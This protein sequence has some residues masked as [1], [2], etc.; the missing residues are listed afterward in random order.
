MVQGVS[1]GPAERRSESAQNDRCSPRTLGLV[2]CL[3]LATVLPAAASPPGGV[4]TARPTGLDAPGTRPSGPGLA[5]PGMLDPAPGANLSPAWNHTPDDPGTV[6]AVVDSGVDR[7]HEDLSRVLE[8]WDAVDEDP[9]P[10]DACGHGTRVAGVLGATRSNGIGAVG[11]ANATILP[12]KVL[13]EKPEG[14]SGSTE[15]LAAAIGWAADAGA[16]VIAVPLG[17]PPPCEDQGVASAIE[18]ASL[19]GSLVVASAGN[20]P[21]AGVYFPA[22][23]PDA[24]AVSAL[25]EDGTPRYGAFPAPGPDLLAPGDDL[26]T[27]TLDDGYGRLSGASA[28]VPV[29]AAAAGMVLSVRDLPPGDVVRVLQASATDVG[30]PAAAQGH[31]AIDAGGA[32]E[33]AEEGVPEHAPGLVAT[34]TSAP[35]EAPQ[36][37]HAPLEA[38]AG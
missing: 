18:R 6:V 7:S 36:A 35:S 20:D 16:D 14:C 19:A 4:P 3:L 24:L 38:P 30:A 23:H 11:A 5:G 26:R 10:E 2:A 13:D 37:P 34:L 33:L 17:C 22:A 8:G 28:A 32:V 29:A 21:D 27:T 9:I 31:G 25:D 15:D 1:S 12:V